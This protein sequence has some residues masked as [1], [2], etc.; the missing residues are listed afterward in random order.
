M[1]NAMLI[2]P[3]VHNHQYKYVRI[4]PYIKFNDMYIAKALD[5]AIIKLG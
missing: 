4:L 1:C 5:I 3:P 2:L